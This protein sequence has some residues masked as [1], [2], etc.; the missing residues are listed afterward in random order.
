MIL[1]GKIYDFAFSLIFTQLFFL[2]MKKTNNEV[3]F[4]DREYKKKYQ[5]QNE[6][7]LINADE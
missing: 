4:L 6:D 3:I 7:L 5:K 2:T 1:Y